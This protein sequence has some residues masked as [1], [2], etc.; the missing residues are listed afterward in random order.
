MLGEVQWS[1]IRISVLLGSIKN[2]TFRFVIVSGKWTTTTPPCSLINSF[3]N[4]TLVGSLPVRLDH[5]YWY[6]Q[7]WILLW[8]TVVANT[9]FAWRRP[10][11]CTERVSPME[12]VVEWICIISCKLKC[13]WSCPTPS[14]PPLPVH[15][16]T[17]CL[18]WAVTYTTIVS[19]PGLHTQLLSH[20]VRK[21]GEG[22]DGF[23]TW[24][25]PR[26][27]SCS[28]GSHLGLFSPLH[29]SFPDFSS[30]FLFSLSWESDCYWIDRG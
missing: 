8:R 12:K 5:E 9:F 13:M 28:V 19:L 2:W 17:T 30:F 29:S 4:V 16:T 26:L 15:Y 21:A 24:C 20:A 6:L 23:I 27:T 7:L 18:Y 10:S 11:G 3:S 14:S 22:L 25:M 1:T